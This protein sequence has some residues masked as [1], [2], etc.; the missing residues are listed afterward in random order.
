MSGTRACGTVYSLPMA[1]L[2][3]SFAALSLVAAE[4]V[5][6]PPKRKT[7]APT[8]SAH[9]GLTNDSASAVALVVLSRLYRSRDEAMLAAA[10]HTPFGGA[11]LAALRAL[12][13]RVAVAQGAASIQR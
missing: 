8:P 9:W 10:A 13:L 12:A 2:M 5:G 1:M 3:P 6:M 11:V 7:T 4:D